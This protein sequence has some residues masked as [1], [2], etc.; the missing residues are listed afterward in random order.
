M[1]RVQNF[2]TCDTWSTSIITYQEVKTKRGIFLQS[3]IQHFILNNKSN[4]TLYFYFNTFNQQ[5]FYTVNI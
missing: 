5:I 2:A 3:L 1:S 4:A